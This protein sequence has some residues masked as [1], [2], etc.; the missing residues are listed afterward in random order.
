MLRIYLR[1]SL[2]LEYDGK[3][4]LREGAFRARQDRLLFA[5][6]TLHRDRAVSREE[7][8]QVLWPGPDEAASDSALKALLSRLRSC[9]EPAG[10]AGLA[11][12][13][14]GGLVDLRAPAETW[15]DLEA[16]ASYVD[17]A[18]AALRRGDAGAAFGPSSATTILAA[19][20][21]LAGDQH[22]WAIQVRD[23]LLRQR[24]RALDCLAS[25]WLAGG[26]PVLAIEAASEAL[27]LD[28]NRDTSCRL[29]LQAHQAAG[30][31]AAAVRAYLEFRTG[32]RESL[33]I[34][35]SPETERLYL[36][37]LG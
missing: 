2:I 13:T 37:V 21:F 11:L 20:P 30:N 17:A 12:G 6:L 27:S 35:P 33:G 19:R 32:L 18:E 26:E 24:L 28:P 34:D 36:A 23:R 1:E 8:A 3:V 4:V 29:L 7:L 25:V 10:A 31:P 16:A 15:V 5:Y 9:L 22:P 14:S